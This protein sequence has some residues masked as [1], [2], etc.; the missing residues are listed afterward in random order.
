MDNVLATIY[1]FWKNRSHKDKTYTYQ[2]LLQIKAAF[3]NVKREADELCSLNLPEVDLFLDKIIDFLLIFDRSH[4]TK[5]SNNP[6]KKLLLLH[7]EEQSFVAVELLA[8]A[9]EIQDNVGY[10]LTFKRLYTLASKA[11]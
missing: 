10:K 4:L 9:Y 3:S 8:L 2:S 7:L 11:I 1:A 6:L 5:D